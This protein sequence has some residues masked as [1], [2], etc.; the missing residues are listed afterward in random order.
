MVSA[1]ISLHVNSERKT[2]IYNGNTTVTSQILV[3][4]IATFNQLSGEILLTKLHC[5]KDVSLM[6]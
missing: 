1:G 4:A 3:I 5:R 6:G 2:R